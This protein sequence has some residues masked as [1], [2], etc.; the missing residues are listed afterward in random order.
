MQQ[1]KL[2]KRKFK[3][4][5]L[6][7]LRKKA[8]ENQITYKTTSFSVPKSRD[9]SLIVVNQGKASPLPGSSIFRRAA[10]WN[11]KNLQAKKKQI[12][13]VVKTLEVTCGITP[14]L[15]ALN[16]KVVQACKTKFVA[17][18]GEKI[19][20]LREQFDLKLNKVREMNSEL[21][22]EAVKN[23]TFNFG[24]SKSNGQ[25]L[26]FMMAFESN[27]EKEVN[28][29]KK[30]SP[31]APREWQDKVNP[32]EFLELLKD[33]AGHEDDDIVN[34]ERGKWTQFGHLILEKF[35]LKGRKWETNVG[36]ITKYYAM[37]ITNLE[38]VIRDSK[39]RRLKNIDG[40]KLF[41]NFSLDD[42]EDEMLSKYSVQV[43][44]DFD[45]SLF[46]GDFFFFLFFL[47]FFLFPPFFLLFFLFFF[48]KL[49]FFQKDE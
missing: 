16:K 40:F 29:R 18:A 48:F 36:S 21:L 38:I 30:Y 26:K 33:F 15:L 17:A 28:S 9:S 46:T 32:E 44:E 24:L 8:P 45:L 10:P 19:K 6:K 47:F 5:R 37:K 43:G 14:E 2:S 25:K 22:R 42:L 7:S 27:T 13:Q 35:D 31:Y 3:E 11:Q 49:Y 12:G 23:A 41:K 4:V 34:L 1:K 39:R 20:A